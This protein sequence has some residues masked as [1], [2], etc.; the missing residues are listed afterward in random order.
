MGSLSF[1]SLCSSLILF[2]FQFP[3]CH[4]LGA[5]LTLR[6]HNKVAEFLA[7]EVKKKYSSDAQDEFSDVLTQ[8]KGPDGTVIYHR[9][10][11]KQPVFITKD[12]ESIGKPVV[13]I[14]RGED[15]L[16]VEDKSIFV[17]LRQRAGKQQYNIHTAAV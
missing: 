14:K 4:S 8:V 17:V 15:Y 9:G 5:L 11:P 3:S 16:L 10:D 6:E 13:V 1:L 2:I 12:L 7:S